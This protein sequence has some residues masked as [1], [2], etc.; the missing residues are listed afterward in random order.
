[1]RM[2]KLMLIVAL[3]GC[4]AGESAAPEGLYFAF[5]IDGGVQNLQPAAWSFAPDGR[6]ETEG[7][8]GKAKLARGRMSIAWSDGETD[9]GKIDSPGDQF[10]WNDRLF[11]RVEPFT[12]A[13]IVGTWEDGESRMTLREDGTFEGGRW[14]LDGHTL[15][16]TD[17][18]GKAD[19]RIA[20][21]VDAETLLFG[22]TLY[23]R[24][25]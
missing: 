2:K 7:R 5:R 10:L 19:R 1:M 21:P 6:V 22:A 15:T 11:T 9:E 3:A 20:L 16:L 24:K 23:R 17:A 18:S 4:V 12:T 25:R 14:H 13:A 8:H